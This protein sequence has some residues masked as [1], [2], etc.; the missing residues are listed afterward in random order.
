MPAGRPRDP[1]VD[2]SI[3]VA[4]RELLVESGYEETTL[5]AIA[6]RAGVSV[7]TL[8]RRWP[9]KHEL[10]EEAALHL[11]TFQLPRPTGDLRADLGAWVRLFLE[12]AMEPAARAA[13]P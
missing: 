13:V 1:S 5:A 6:R 8:Y 12:V 9:G 7:P 4:A 10:I 11:D 2:E 3:R